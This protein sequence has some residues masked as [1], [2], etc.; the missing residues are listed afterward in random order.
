MNQLNVDLGVEE[1][2]LGGA[3]LRFNP[4]DPNLY[5][6]FLDLEAQLQELQQELAQKTRQATDA[7]SVM[8]QLEATDRQVKELLTRVFG[9]ENDFSRLLRGVNLLSVG[10]NG[11]SVAENLLSALEPVLTRGAERFVEH[12]T[13]AAREKARLRRESL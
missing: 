11:L 13:Q 9:E 6:R 3:V 2:D 1:F 12:K 4:T 7:F 8:K 10:S 5:A